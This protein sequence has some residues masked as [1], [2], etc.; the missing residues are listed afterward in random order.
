[1]YNT[2]DFGHILHTMPIEFDCVRVTTVD[3]LIENAPLPISHGEMVTAGEAVG[4]FIAWPKRL[5]TLGSQ[6]YF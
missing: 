3:P 2:E 4:S 1:M 5:I 6:V